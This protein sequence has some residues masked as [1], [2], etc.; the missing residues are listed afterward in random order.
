VE[1]ILVDNNSLHDNHFMRMSSDTYVYNSQNLGFTKA[2]NQG[3]KL[4]TKPY[5]VVGNDDYFVKPGWE[6]ALVE[7]LD[8]YPQVATITPFTKEGPIKYNKDIWAIFLPGSWFM[9]R[10]KTFDKLGLFDEQ[11]KNNHADTDLAYRIS[12]LKM[13]CAETS[14]TKAEHIGGTSLKR[15]PDRDKEYQESK[16]LFEEKW[17][18]EQLGQ[19]QSTQPPA[20]LQENI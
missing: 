7:I 18:L 11:F 2:V 17:E 10:R 9:M 13:F 20:D 3:L 5:I 6:D 15:Y 8:T 19:D 14:L 1:L 12:Q 4:A 16:K